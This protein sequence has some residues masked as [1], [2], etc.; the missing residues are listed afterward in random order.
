MLAAIDDAAKPSRDGTD[1]SEMATNAA[2]ESLVGIAGREGPGLFGA[3]GSPDETRAALAR[4]GTPR[5][6]GVVAR[7]FVARLIRHCVDYFLSRELPNH[8]G[9][10]RRYP[11]LNEHWEFEQA[12]TRHCREVS[13]IVERFAAEWFSKTVFEGGITPDKAGRFAHV[14]F[15]KARYE[16][17]VRHAGAPPNA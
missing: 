2:V 12:L 4:L 3:A 7:D 6:F 16:L 8:V 15:K 1:F 10:S 9:P 14:L 17:R 5:E 11:S 13:E